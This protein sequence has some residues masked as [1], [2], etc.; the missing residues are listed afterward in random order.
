M[1]MGLLL[2][3]IIYR[4]WMDLRGGKKLFSDYIDMLISCI[5]HKSLDYIG[6]IKLYRLEKLFNIWYYLFEDFQH[7]VL[8][9]LAYY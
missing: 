1:N 2:L 4:P 6:I 5:S 8:Q 7:I 3:R 9:F